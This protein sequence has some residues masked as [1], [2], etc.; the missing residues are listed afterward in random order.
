M[1]G[2]TVTSIRDWLEAV[3]LAKYAGVFAEHEITLEMVPD[4]TALDIDRLGLPTGPR[5]QLL[6]AIQRRGGAARIEPSVC[7]P[8]ASIGVTIVWLPGR[9]KFRRRTRSRCRRRV[10]GGLASQGQHGG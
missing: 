4:L 6:V 2:R 5:R 3:G 1:N 9:S 8:H 7:V 10:S